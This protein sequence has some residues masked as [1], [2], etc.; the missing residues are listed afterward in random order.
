MLLDVRVSLGPGGDLLAVGQVDARLG[1]DLGLGA[2]EGLRHVAL[3]PV[4]VPAEALDDH[5]V[6]VLV[7]EGEVV[8]DVPDLLRVADR[9]GGPPA[10]PARLDRVGLHGPVGDV[11]V[12]DVLLDDVV[13]AQPQEVVPVVELVLRRRS[14]PSR[15]CG[16][17]AAARSSSTRADRMS[18]NSPSCICLIVSTYPAW[19]RRWVPADDLELLLLGLLGRVQHLADAGHVH[20]DRLLGEDVLAGLDR[21]LQV[22][23]AEPRRGGE[24]DVVDVGTVSSF[25]YPSSPWNSGVVGGLHLVGACRSS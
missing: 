8:P 25:L 11:Q 13:A 1:V 9:A 21:R 23:R 18:P 7:L 5:P 16:T 15:A 14:S 24:D 10:H 2:D 19:C 20:R 12:V 6:R 4:D 17:R 22:V 3:R